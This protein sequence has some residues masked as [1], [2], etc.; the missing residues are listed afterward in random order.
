MTWSR[1]IAG[2]RLAG[3]AVFL[4]LAW[5]LAC[6]GS[7]TELPPAPANTP[8]T[9]PA[10]ATSAPATL[11]PTAV[12]PTN[13]PAAAMP[14]NASGLEVIL[15]TTVLEVGE[16]RLA[17]ILASS[18]G[19]L[20]DADVTVTPVYLGDGSEDGS[21]GAMLET[22]F[23]LWPYGVR[24]AYATNI[25]FDQA[26]PWRLDIN[27]SGAEASGLATLE[28][29][30]VDE[31]PVPALGAMAPL[32]N[33][34]TLD[35]VGA[36]EKLTTDYSPDPD[37][38][39]I[40]IAEA[41]AGPLPT[42]VVF[43]TP[44]FCTTATCG[45]QVDAVTE[46]KDAHTEEANFIH[47]EIYDNPEEI[48]GNLDRARITETVDEWGLSALPHWFNESWTFILDAE[49]RVRGRFEGFA[50]L[51]ELEASLASVSSGG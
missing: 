42:V 15:A 13:T 30:V 23:H 19:L 40:S 8:T 25:E 7:A 34:K 47:I 14:E 3:L 51:V 16:Q 5:T 18:K 29:E 43:A 2:C 33:S 27:V 28:I 32:S 26:G 17:F 36:I 12:A 37:L 50:T 44:A 35:G 11:A 4:A 6:G 45:P 49:G 10:A 22:S 20:K 48:Q 39:R 21:A 31:S 38:Y 46:L 1:S 41:V 9:I 24:G